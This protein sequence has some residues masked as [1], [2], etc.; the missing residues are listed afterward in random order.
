VL[1]SDRDREFESAFLQRRVRRELV[2][3]GTAH[4]SLREELEQFQRNQKHEGPKIVVISRG[5]GSSNPSPSSGESRANLK[6]TSTSRFRHS[7]S[8]TRRSML[9][10]PSCILA[11][12]ILRQPPV[13]SAAGYLARGLSVRT[14]DGDCHHG[15]TAGAHYSRIAGLKPKNGHLAPNFATVSKL[16]PPEPAAPAAFDWDNG[17]R[18]RW[19]RWTSAREC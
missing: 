12:R 2:S 11:S 1:H 10:V 17:C 3:L 15:Y 8:H 16:W 7:I 6:T 9:A 13:P 19:A 4:R 14:G 5:T 18:G